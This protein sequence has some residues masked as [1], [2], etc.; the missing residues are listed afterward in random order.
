MQPAPCCPRPAAYGNLKVRFDVIIPFFLS[1]LLFMLS[2]DSECDRCYAILEL[3]LFRPPGPKIFCWLYFFFCCFWNRN[4]QMRIGGAGA[5]RYYTNSGP[6]QWRRRRRGHAPRAALCKGR[7]FE[8]RKCGILKS[9]RFWRIGVC[10]ADS[11]ILNPLLNNPR[12]SR[13]F[14]TTPL[15]CQCSTTPHKGVCTPRNL[16]CWSD[17]SFTCCKTVEDSYCPVTV[18]LAIAI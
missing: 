1:L 13:S 2:N 14:R 5:R 4:L 15:N 11:D 9:G 8:G 12:Y 10:I 6:P 16:H 3:R 17:W 18:L 7:H